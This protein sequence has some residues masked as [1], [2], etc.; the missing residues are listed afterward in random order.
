M[1][2]QEFVLASFFAG[3]FVTFLKHCGLLYLLVKSGGNLSLLSAMHPRKKDDCCF[4]FV[5]SQLGS[6]Q[7]VKLSLGGRLENTPVSPALHTVFTQGKM[8]L[9]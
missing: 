6:P 5:Q 4:G 1:F 3:S 7:K 2:I 8:T 9:M